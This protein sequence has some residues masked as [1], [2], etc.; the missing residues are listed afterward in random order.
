MRVYFGVCGIGLGHIG[1]CVPIA[2][3]LMRMGSRVLFSTYRDAVEFVRGEGLPLVEAPP[4]GFVVKADGSVDFRQTTAEPGP[5]SVLIFMRQLTKEIQLMKAFRPDLVVSDSRV[6]TLISARLLGIPGV[7][8]INQYRV[9]I[10][11]TRR[12]LRL[13]RVADGG[14][15]T[16]IGRVWT[17]GR[18][19][20]IPDFPP[21]YT[22]SLGNLW[23]P[24]A[25]RKKVR[26]IGPI[27]PVKPD[28]LPSREEIREKLGFGDDEPV[29][30]APIS[31][32]AKEKA[33]FTGVLR[34]ILR[35]LPNDYRVVMTLGYP[36]MGLK[37]IKSGNMTV[38]GWLP[39]R[40]EYM[41]AC[42][43]IVARSGLGTVTQSICYGKPAVFVPTPNHTEQLNNAKRAEVLGIAK[44]IPQEE[45]GY[46][47][48]FPSI[49]ELL[50]RDAYRRRAERAQRDVSRYDAIEVA[51][52]LISD[53]GHLG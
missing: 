46:K 30:F 37:P 41:K 2:R 13:A 14:I 5:F 1:R 53:L 4:I 15:L 22:I 27:I 48:L 20:L 19:V 45:L 50:T 28:T 6:S 26:L 25:R 17:M 31:G 35:K 16:V 23:I 9:V 32:P 51:T 49:E 12:F 34:G 24:P 29:I 7:T 40:F 11:R 47:N 52:E 43:L 18:Y 10:P 21:P 33:Y 3:R 36:N 38:Y 8:I 42:D 39:N 44:V